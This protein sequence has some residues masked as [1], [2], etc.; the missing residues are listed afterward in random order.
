MLMATYHTRNLDLVRINGIDSMHVADIGLNAQ[1]VK[2]YEQDK[3]RGILTYAKYLFGAVR[4][5][6]TYRFRFTVDGKQYEKKGAMLAIANGLA[7]DI[8]C[9]HMGK[10]RDAAQDAK[11]YNSHK[12]ESCNI[13]HRTTRFPVFCIT[14]FQSDFHCCIAIDEDSFW[15]DDS[16][17]CI[18][19]CSRST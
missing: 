8:E 17:L 4:A 5:Q 3:N 11:H 16:L 19:S 13:V 14:P 7:F 10:Q 9:I 18:S 2:A 12:N 15:H 6:E 1:L